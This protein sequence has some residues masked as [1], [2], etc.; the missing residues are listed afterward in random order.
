MELYLKKYFWVVHVL[1]IGICAT[2]VAKGANHVVEAKLFLTSP[3][4]SKTARP[5]PVRTAPQP[6]PQVNTKDPT[7]VAE[8]NIFCSTC[9]PATPEPATQTSETL[10]DPSTPQPTTLPL[11]LLATSISVRNQ[12]LSSA[13]ITNTQSQRSGSYWIH[14]EIP[15]AGEIIAITPRW[16]DFHNRQ[17][18][19]LERIDLLGAAA[20]AATTSASPPPP[21]IPAARPTGPEGELIA[22]L[23][24]K[25]RKVDE[26]HYE[27]ERSMVE[28]VLNDP[29]L[30]ARQAR[31]VPS[32]K[33]GKA[34][35]FKLYAIR[36]NS[37]YSKI[38]LQ[39]GD[40]LHAV[41]G[42]EITSPDK[43]LEVYTKVRSQSNLS[44]QI[45]RRGQA[46]TLEYAIK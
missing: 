12:L 28:R 33:D 13:T 38:G 16:V 26:S 4:R 14:E 19:R 23:D 35:G 1:I 3:A 18:N 22:E 32:I 43:A 15:D 24:T 11:A 44:I 21:V 39:N 42:M 25:V 10:A 46:M 31:I 2:I 7:L 34:N 8:R 20:A 40:T 37:V 30:I 6:K 27:I 45:S 29:A 9:Q 17:A 41:N 5:R 36:P